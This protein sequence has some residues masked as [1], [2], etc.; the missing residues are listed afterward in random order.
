MDFIHVNS[1]DV[2][3]AYLIVTF[4]AT[5]SSVE[6]AVSSLKLYSLYDTYLSNSQGQERFLELSMITSEN[7]MMVELKRSPI[8]Y[9]DVIK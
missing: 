6:H 5:S 1:L 2:V 3:I 8:F 7:Q 9:S 4:P